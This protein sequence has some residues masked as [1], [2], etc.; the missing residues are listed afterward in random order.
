MTSRK[1][2]AGE[3]NLCQTV[4]G[5]S[6]RYDEVEIHA[7]KF[8]PFQPAGT[9]MA[10]EG[11]L[12]MYGC[13]QDDYSTM[14]LHTQA[15]FIHEMT[16]V[17][18]FQQ[19]ILEPISAAIDLNIQHLFNY[20]AAYLYLLDPKKDLLAYNMEQQATIVQDY[21]VMRHGDDEKSL[22][23]QNRECAADRFAMMEKV[24]EN[25]LNDPHYAKRDSFPQKA[26]RPP[27]NK[28]D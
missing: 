24:L 16:H 21:F 2:T 7:G 15:H 23:C 25:F 9:A 10:P 12:Y 28:R 4:F 18:Q 5:S 26:K 14:G 22:K 6:I 1:L 8:M 3:I 13:Y 27:K 11:N 17:W 20:R 19:K